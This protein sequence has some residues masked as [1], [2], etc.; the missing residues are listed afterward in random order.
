[1]HQLPA[2]RKLYLLEQHKQFRLTS[3]KP[4]SHVAQ[5]SYPV[6]YGPSSASNLLPRLVPQ[7]TGD[8]GLIKRLSITGW[9]GASATSPS[10]ASVSNRKGETPEFSCASDAQPTEG[11]QPLQPQTTGGLWSSW[12]VSSGGEKNAAAQSKGLVKEART[13]KWYVDNIEGKALNTKLVKQLIS[14]RV[15]L[16]TARVLWVEEFVENEAGLDALGTILA[17][18]VGRAGKRKHLADIEGAVLLEV[19]KILRVLSNTEVSWHSVY[20]II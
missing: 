4:R 3:A 12:W 20:S 13:P 6:T 8:S 16:S 18:L 17:G 2:D 9:G 15:H 11:L 1:M 7:L 5:S 10:P 14:L 19:M